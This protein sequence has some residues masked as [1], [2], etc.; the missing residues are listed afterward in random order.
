[1]ATPISA[2]GPSRL[3]PIGIVAHIHRTGT[4][5]LLAITTAASHISYDDGTLGAEGNH[6]QV[7]Q[8]HA[9]NP[10]GEWAVTLEDDAQP[11]PGFLAQLDRA[12]EVAP[13]PIVSLYL[14][15][16][17][18]TYWQPRI[19]QAITT[20]RATDASWITTNGRLLH[21]VGVAIRTP[22][23]P[24]L[25]EWLT[26]SNHAI[27]IAISAW[28]QTNNHTVGYTWPSLINHADMP[29]I[30][31]HHDSMPRNRPR[32]AWHTDQRAHW[33]RRATPIPE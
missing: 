2:D 8:H 20:A 18:R 32:I 11:V 15:I 23:L 21:A 5:E 7:W 12:L 25:L 27:D 14:G 4:A 13:T 9:D 16:D 6:Q 22:L 31:K 29:S 10:V 17:G 24:S 19:E 1:M 26:N 28:A 30:A 33:T 3:N